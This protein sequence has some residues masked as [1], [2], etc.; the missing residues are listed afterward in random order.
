MTGLFCLA[1]KTDI[2][3]G[4]KHLA[5]DVDFVEWG[6]QS[7][8]CVSIK[9]LILRQSESSTVPLIFGPSIQ[10]SEEKE[11]R[12]HLG[13]GRTQHI[14]L[15]NS[16]SKYHFQFFFKMVNLKLLQEL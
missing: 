11:K 14:L 4:N 7:T 13:G 16:R 5:K 6:P 10:I 15:F 9:A 1:C 3:V 12:K 8:I 2:V